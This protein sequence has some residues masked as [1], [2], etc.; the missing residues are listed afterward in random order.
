MKKGIRQKHVVRQLIRKTRPGIPVV[1]ADRE[2]WVQ[3][4]LGTLV[5]MAFALK[6]E[7][8]VAADELLFRYAMNGLIEGAAVEIIHT[9]GL[10][11]S[12][13]N[14]RRPDLVMR[15]SPDF[16]LLFGQNLP[17]AVRPSIGERDRV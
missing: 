15:F 7:R 11:P 17:F 5:C 4:R 12:Y 3:D 10:R 2:A 8:R 6:L 1:N 9:L 16:A 13:V 14:I